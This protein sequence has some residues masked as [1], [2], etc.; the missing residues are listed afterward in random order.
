MIDI[1]LIERETNLS[2]DEF[3][4]LFKEI[5]LSEVIKYY[6]NSG[7]ENTLKGISFYGRRVD[8]NKYREFNQILSNKNLRLLMSYQTRT[9]RWN[10]FEFPEF[11]NTD[12]LIDIDKQC[13][14]VIEKVDNKKLLSVVYSYYDDKSTFNS[15]TNNWI[16][17]FGLDVL[18]NDY[19][20]LVLL[21][22]E[23]NE[24]KTEI[25]S[26]IKRLLDYK[27]SNEITDIDSFN[28]IFEN[29]PIIQLYLK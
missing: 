5:R 27:I 28:A 26:D 17:K 21:F 6:S 11:S 14:H 8:K 13:Y 9:K 7:N 25:F 20:D 22:N 29:W 16:D 4:N 12:K 24:F 18:W 1:D 3:D 19:F 15:I 23:N 10:D 2:G